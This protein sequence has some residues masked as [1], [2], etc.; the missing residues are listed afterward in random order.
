MCLRKAKRNA[1]IVNAILITCINDLTKAKGLIESLGYYNYVFKVEP[2]EILLNGDEFDDEYYYEITI[3]MKY[4]SWSR[5]E[6]KLRKK[7]EKLNL[8]HCLYGKIIC[9]I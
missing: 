4:N 9:D 3:K 8:R 7:L 5:F 1:L 2:K 6:K